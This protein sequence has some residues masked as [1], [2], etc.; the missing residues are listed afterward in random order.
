LAP[1]RVPKIITEINRITSRMGGRNKKETFEI[2]A[3]RVFFAGARWPIQDAMP[4]GLERYLTEQEYR[5][6]LS[7]LQA[8]GDV[9]FKKTCWLGCGLYQGICAGLFI[10]Q[11]KRKREAIL[12][13]WAQKGLTIQ[14]F[15]GTKYSGPSLKIIAPASRKLEAGSG[16]ITHSATFAI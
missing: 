9:F 8:D 7:T 5:D 6:T 15:G 1:V 11:L 14:I 4:L 2:A 13:P 12:Q 10:G 16:R 3:K